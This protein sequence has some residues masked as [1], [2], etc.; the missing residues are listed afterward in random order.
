MEP[1][2]WTIF[3]VFYSVQWPISSSVGSLRKTTLGSSRHETQN[4]RTTHLSTAASHTNTNFNFDNNWRAFYK[5]SGFSSTS[6]NPTAPFSFCSKMWIK[7]VK[8][9]SYAQSFSERAVE[10][11]STSEHT[12][13]IDRFIAAVDLMGVL[14]ATGT[15]YQCLLSKMSNQS[16]S[17][18]SFHSQEAM[19]GHQKRASA[20][21]DVW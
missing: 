15:F 1:V 9:A 3:R 6:T 7:I 2:L 5:R 17:S 12:C 4:Y 18:M 8:N 20:R 10:L 14:R 21:C 19:R 16:Y 11:W 13:P